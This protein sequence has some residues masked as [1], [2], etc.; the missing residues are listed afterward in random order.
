MLNADQ[1]R[2]EWTPEKK[3]WHVVIQVGAEVI[4]RWVKNPQNSGDDALRSLAVE[5]AK[6]EGYELEA[7]RV[8][9]VR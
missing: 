9:V 1:A 6:D 7:S 3:Q 2:V 4:K 8:S 5:T